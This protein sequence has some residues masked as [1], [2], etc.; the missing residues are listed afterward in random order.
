MFEEEFP[1]R[2]LLLTY[3]E[4]RKKKEIFQRKFFL[5]GSRVLRVK[6]KEVNGV[7]T[8]EISQGLFCDRALFTKARALL[9]ISKLTEMQT[10]EY[11]LLLE[12]DL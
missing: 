5:E 1:K 7:W 4:L 12:S 6:K 9:W 3:M 10:S 11:F 2:L 8:G